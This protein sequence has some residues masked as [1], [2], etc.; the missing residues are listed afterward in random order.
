MLKNNY[1]TAFKEN[2][3]WINTLTYNNLMGLKVYS[4]EEINNIYDKLTL[5]EV[6]KFIHDNLLGADT[7]ISIFNPEQ[8]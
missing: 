1:S 5:E 4:L 7:F 2:K 6:N 8:K 3:Y